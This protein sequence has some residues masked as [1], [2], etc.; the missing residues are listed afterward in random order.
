MDERDKP[1]GSG[2]VHEGEA[3]GE[4]QS[5][6]HHLADAGDNDIEAPL[7]DPAGNPAV[8]AAED[9]SGRQPNSRTGSSNGGFNQS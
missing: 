8:G 5:P 3:G 4:V 6:S 2:G 1:G 9:K 7:Q